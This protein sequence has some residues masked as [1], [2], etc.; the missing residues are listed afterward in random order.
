[1]EEPEK[2]VLNKRT[3][4]YSCGCKREIFGFESCLPS[5]SCEK[6][7]NPVSGEQNETDEL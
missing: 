1:M 7:G 6:H 5:S 2:F 3:I 4:L